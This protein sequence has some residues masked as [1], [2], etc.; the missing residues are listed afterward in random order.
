MNDPDLIYFEDENGEEIAY[1]GLRYFHSEGQEYLLLAPQHQTAT[2]ENAIVLH[3][4]QQDD[5]E[6]LSPVEPDQAEALLGMALAHF[7]IN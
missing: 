2:E 7:D 3:V 4:Q 6:I 5:E 1:L